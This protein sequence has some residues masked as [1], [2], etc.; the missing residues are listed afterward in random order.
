M[1]YYCSGFL[2]NENLTPLL[3][4]NNVKY[5]LQK[6]SMNSNNLFAEKHVLRRFKATKIAYE[7]KLFLPSNFLQAAF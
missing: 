5:L 2:F 3:W 7:S 1:P 4:Q 6:K